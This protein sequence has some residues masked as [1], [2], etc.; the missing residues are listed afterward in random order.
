MYSAFQNHAVQTPFVHVDARVALDE[1]NRAGAPGA[2]ASGRMDFRE[3]DRI[4]ENELNDILWQSIHG[5][6][7]VP[8]APVHA[9]FVRP[10]GNGDGD[11]DDVWDRVVSH[12]KPSR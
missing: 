11:D 7:A 3:A 8:P 5:A 2:D 12:A 10:V 1:M 4:P 9:A 6:H